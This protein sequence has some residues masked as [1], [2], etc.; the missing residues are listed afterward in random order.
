MRDEDVQRGSKRGELGP[1]AIWK[2]M[3]CE[4]TTSR[5]HLS[6]FFLRPAP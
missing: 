4:R 2:Q 5:M 1:H 3:K 6:G